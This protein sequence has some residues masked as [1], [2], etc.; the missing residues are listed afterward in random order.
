MATLVKFIKEPE[1]GILAVFPQLFHQNK[2]FANR[3]L[4]C[5]SHTDQ[6]SS[7]DQKYATDCELATHDEYT[8]LELELRGIGYDLEILNK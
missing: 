3:Q 5:Y 2:S 6:H 4:T 7:C 1:G 8:S